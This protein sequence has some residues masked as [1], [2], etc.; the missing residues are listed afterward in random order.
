LFSSEETSFLLSTPAPADQVFA[1]KYQGAVAFSS[2]AFV[3]LGSPILIAYGL[4]LDQTPWYFYLVL[5]LFFLGFVLIP[6]S[7]G[8]L[9]CLLIVN[10]VPR[11]RKQVLMLGGL[12]VAAGAAWFIYRTVLVSRGNFGSR[13]WV[14]QLLGQ[15]SLFQGVLVP[16][17][18]MARG[19]E[20]TGRDQP[21]KV[22]YYLALVWSN[23][24]LLYVLAAWTAQRLYRRGYNRVAT[25]GTIRRR[26]G[27]GWLDGLVGSTLG[28]LAPQTRLLIIK[29]FRTFRRDPAQWA[30]ILIFVGLAS[31][32]FTN[33]GRFQQQDISHTT[34][35]NVIGVLNLA[36]TAF[37][38]CAYTGRF[39]Y[40]MLSLEGRK[41]WILGL[42]PLQRDRL[43]L[44]KFAFSAM[45]SLVIA[46]FVVNFSNLMLSA[47][48]VTIGLHSLTVAV[49]ALGLSGLSVG[50]G[51]SMPN[52]QERDPSKLAVGFG[53]TLNLV[54]GL[55]YLL[56]VIAVMVLPWHIFVAF[57]G[58]DREINSWIV[59][60]LL[61][62]VT[63]GIVLGVVA[64]VVP[65]R[66]G[67]RALRRMEF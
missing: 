17:Q 19:L 2:W 50:L 22:C 37:L 8:A 49:L 35:K 47:G 48:W 29:D 52:F 54:A 62:G 20:A 27:G 33:V 63:V 34:Q 39:I 16:A 38:L 4:I 56:V 28:W 23:G 7:I 59:G 45:G 9:L 5:P 60:W 36:A 42:L 55:L 24:L 6:G 66:M 58:S 51:A 26:Y 64:V 41:F 13:D 18:W 32:Y 25:G 3:L 46:E 1:F 57:Q 44:G 67:I 40:P 53:G 65:L 61:A 31:L 14:N 43:L 15:F 21:V 10:Y 30:Q 11:R 12:V